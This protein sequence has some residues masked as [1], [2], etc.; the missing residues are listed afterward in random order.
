MHWLANIVTGPM[1]YPAAVLL[2]GGV[3]KGT[4]AG[5]RTRHLNGPAR[6][7]KFLEIDRRQNG[8]VAA[9]KTGLWLED[10][11]L[12]VA[13]G[14]IIARR[15]VGVDYAGRHWAGKRYNLSIT[16]QTAASALLRASPPSLRRAPRRPRQAAFCRR[17][18]TRRYMHRACFQL[19]SAF[20]RP[21]REFT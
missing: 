3:Y 20:P 15:R 21:C 2:R 14:A 13:H 4:R 9:R 1:D 7:T 18:R 17:S 10:R 16:A 6:L 19:R 12:A 11:G 5:G 8:K